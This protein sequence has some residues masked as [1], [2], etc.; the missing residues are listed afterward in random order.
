MNRYFTVGIFIL[1][2]AMSC[3]LTACGGDKYAIAIENKDGKVIHDNVIRYRITDDKDYITIEKAWS[4]P[5]TF[6]I[7]KSKVRVMKN[8]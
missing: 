3:A 7:G 1:L 8:P 6:Y 4:N 5:Q 2:I